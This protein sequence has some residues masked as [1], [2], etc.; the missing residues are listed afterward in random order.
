MVVPA[1]RKLYKSLRVCT[2]SKKTTLW[3]VLAQLLL[4]DVI[5]T[6]ATQPA[7]AVFLLTET[8]VAACARRLN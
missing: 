6:Y 4:H 1:T 5:V 2:P 3:Q 7:P 8:T